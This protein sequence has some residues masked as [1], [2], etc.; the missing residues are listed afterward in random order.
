MVTSGQ[1]KSRKGDVTFI[2]INPTSPALLL[3]QAFKATLVEW[4]ALSRS[5]ATERAVSTW[6]GDSLLEFVGDPANATFV[7]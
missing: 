6:M 1:R 2:G 5:K 7:Y 3:K 4:L